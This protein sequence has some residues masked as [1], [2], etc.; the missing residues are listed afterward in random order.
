MR[1]EDRETTIRCRHRGY[2]LRRTVGIEGVAFGLLP[3]II[4]VAH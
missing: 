2:A 4:N 3:V 1:H